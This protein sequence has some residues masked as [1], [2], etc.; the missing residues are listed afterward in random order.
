MT[1]IYVERGANARIT[2]FTKKVTQNKEVSYFY[3][4]KINNLLLE[5]VSLVKI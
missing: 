5:K 3:L 1:S 4:I 2:N